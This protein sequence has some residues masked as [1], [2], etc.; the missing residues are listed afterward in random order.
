MGVRMRKH[1]IVCGEKL[2]EKPIYVCK[3]MPA[4]AQNLP[5]ESNLESDISMD[6]NLC[7]CSG[8]GLVQFD[9]E[10]VSYYKDSTR[11]GER[12]QALIDLRK[13]QYTHLIEKYCLQGKKI[14]E[15]GAGK[16]GF[17]KTLKEM[18]EYS[19]QEYGIENNPEF[20]N[21][22][23]EV[24]GVN[25]QLGDSECMETQI[26]GAPFDAFVSFAYPARLIEPN[27][28]LQLVS[29][30]LTDNAVGLVQVP[31]LEHL[32]KPGGYFDIT[33]DHIAYYNEATLKFLLRKNGFDILEF[34]EVSE[35]YIYAIVKKRM[36]YDLHTIWGDVA[37]LTDS[38]RKY[39]DKNTRDGKKLAVWCAG[40][41]AFTVLALAETGSKISY[42][43][44]NAEFKKGHYAPVSHVP[45]RGPEHFI[46]EPVDTI[47]ILG[48]IYI[49]EIIKEI[50]EKC[51]T[52]VK[53][54]AM[55]KRGLYEIE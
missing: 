35:L 52:I 46:D 37:P 50:K 16:G 33:R 2:I 19:I 20:V 13:Q 10:P 12:C 11:A 31:S 22:A 15:V 6:I 41:F 42:I 4:E 7:Q 32:L 25:V 27:S 45:I 55:D 24:E 23:C 30:H 38:V 1:C 51:G 34:G 48:P 26:K 9:C 8:C 49:D 21:I 18:S 14:L 5:D 43:I 39:V 53:I 29:K 3:N 17:L 54:A 40:H 44:D 47:L 28:M 36:P